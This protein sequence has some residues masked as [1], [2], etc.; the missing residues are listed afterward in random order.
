ML[1]KIEKGLEYASGLLLAVML[2]CILLQVGGR[3]VFDLGFG[4]TEELARYTM[5]WLTYIGAVVSL[6]QGSHIAIDL[7][8]RKLPK[9]WQL[10]VALLGQVLVAFFLVVMVVMGLRLNSTPAIRRQVSPG[11]QMP[12]LLV[13]SVVPVCGLGMLAALAV[14]VVRN[15]RDLVSLDRK[16]SATDK[17]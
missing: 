4:W 14:N 17:G 6:R 13:Y 11:L 8:V 10:L 16:P 2:L 7:V 9:R 1:E 15:I 3:A 12:T 5:I